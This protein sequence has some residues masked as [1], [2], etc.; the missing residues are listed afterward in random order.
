MTYL[1]LQTFLLLLSSYFFGA[2]LACL[3]KR[4]LMAQR[5]R[6]PAGMISEPAVAAPRPEPVPAPAPARAPA[7][8]VAPQ[9]L[10]PRTYEPIQPRIDIL[11]RPEP[12]PAP[13]ALE[14]DRFDRAFHGAQLP[15]TTPRKMIMEIRPQCLKPVTA[16]G[17]GA[18]KPKPAPQPKPVVQVAPAPQPPAPPQPAAK[19]PQTSTPCL[20]Y[21]SPSPRD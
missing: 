18:D 14:T 4:T 15:D 3:V 16:R 6:V 2:F 20:L 8:V 1:L 10:K 9:P 19:P 13:V 11:P 17:P 12:R 7:P 5:T 21:T